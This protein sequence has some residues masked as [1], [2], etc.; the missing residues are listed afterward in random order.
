MQL[1]LMMILVVFSA[2]SGFVICSMIVSGRKGIM[3]HI[4][5]SVLALLFTLPVF[6]DARLPVVN[7]AS[8]GVSA[9]AAFGEP[10]SVASKKNIATQKCCC[11][12]CC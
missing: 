6:A 4:T 11:T 5:I 3:R 9:R 7:L 2:C 12:S 1:F 8:G 10:V